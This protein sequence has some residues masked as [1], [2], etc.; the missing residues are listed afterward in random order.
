MS[1]NTHFAS[2]QRNPSNARQ[3][4]QPNFKLGTQFTVNKKLEEEY[5]DVSEKN[6]L[7]LKSPYYED[8]NFYHRNN[9]MGFPVEK[10]EINLSK[11]IS[12]FHHS[13]VSNFEQ[14]KEYLPKDKNELLKRYIAYAQKN[15]ENYYSALI[16]KIRNTLIY[17][18]NMHDD[19]ENPV[20]LSEETIKDIEKTLDESVNPY[21]KNDTKSISTAKEKKQLPI[22][23]N[24]ESPLKK[25]RSN[26][27]VDLPQEKSSSDK[28]A[29][30]HNSG[31]VFT[32][33]TSTNDEKTATKTDTT[34]ANK[35][36]VQ[37]LIKKFNELSEKR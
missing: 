18:L 19:P 23:T 17:Y 4:M 25:I 30:S 11:K 24:T 8:Y 3:A 32:S 16:A 28:T 22:D 14:Y 9:M 13:Y 21:F 20:N 35:S 29:S 10:S 26:T 37:K 34:D 27:P 2:Q 1:I 15:P 5:I 36:R 31:S 7:H 12:D 6:K 33:E